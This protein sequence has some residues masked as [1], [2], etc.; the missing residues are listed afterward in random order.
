MRKN[1]AFEFG[2]FNS[3]SLLAFLLCSVG[4]FLAILGFGAV[5]PSA[6]KQSTSVSVFADQHFLPLTSK[7][8]AANGPLASAVANFWRV[9]DSPNISS[10][11]QNILNAATCV[12]V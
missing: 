9:V 11:Q 7:D 2:V 12:S 6:L 4:F 1:P 8:A 10:A 5:P 3:R